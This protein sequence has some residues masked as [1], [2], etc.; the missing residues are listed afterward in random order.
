MHEVPHSAFHVDKG[1]LFSIKQLTV[2]PGKAIRDYI[3]GKRIYHFPP[4]TYMILIT[5]IYVVIKG[6][7]IYFH[8]DEIKPS[9]EFQRKH[10]LAFFLSIIPLYALIY[11]LFHRKYGYNYWQ[12]LVAQTYITGH[13]ILIMTIPN[14]ILFLFPVTRDSA[15]D[16]FIV[17]AFGYFIYAYYQ[18]H[19]NFVKSKWKLLFRELIC[20]FI[21]SIVALGSAIVVFGTLSKYIKH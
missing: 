6:L 7:Q 20:F 8:F 5:T 14:I 1:I 4:L 3:D 19:K 15:K 18:I 16:Y 11:W 9:Q 17:I 12:I 13:F 10:Q 21:A 2:N